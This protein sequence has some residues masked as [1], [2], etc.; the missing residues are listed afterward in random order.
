MLIALAPP[1]APRLHEIR[2]DALVLGFTALITLL[3]VMVSG[4]APAGA[5]ARVHLTASLRDGG[6]EA[7]STGRLRAGLVIAEIAIALVLVVGAALLVQTP[8]LP[9]PSRG[10]NASYRPTD[11]VTVDLLGSLLMTETLPAM[12]ENG[13][14]RPLRRPK[15]LAEHLQVTLGVD[16][17]EQVSPLSDVAGSLSSEDAQDCE[18]SSIV[19]SSASIAVSGDRVAL[20]TSVA[21]DVLANK[22]NDLLSPRVGEHLLPVPVVGELRYGPQ[23]TQGDRESR[24]GGTSR[25]PGHILNV[26]SHMPLGRVWLFLCCMLL[27]AFAAGQDAPDISGP[28]T[29]TAVRLA[30]D[31]RLELDGVL[32]EPVWQRATP[33]GGFLQREPATGA[34]A[35]EP[36]EVRVVYDARRLVL[37]VV[38]H[39]SQPEAILQNEMRRDGSFDADDSFAWVIDSFVDGRTGYFFEINPAGAMGDG[40][41]A[42][43]AGGGGGGGGGGGIN[44]SW[45]GI[46]IARVRRIETGW[47]AEIEIPFRTL[48]FN[49]DLTAW[50]INFRRTVRRKNEESLWTGYALNQGL[51]R[52]INAGRLEGLQGLSQGVG[53]DIKPYVVGHLSSAPAFGRPS[54]TATSA[55]TRSTTS[56]PPC[57]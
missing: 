44:R 2:I 38:L 57:S 11:Q 45:D 47:T 54:G 53:L 56:R 29:F 13:A 24:Q 20:D 16:V 27:P 6:R 33:A 26:T 23:L 34:P 51:T 18:R 55:S 14:F 19:S 39:D 36:T 48:N 17:P 32:D 15:G 42:L 3:T 28:R 30:P 50:G 12:F 25:G 10:A 9:L 4:L 49:P 40:L 7:T 31:E 43:S 52:V 21:I 35:T 41:V 5:A 8:D 22:A 46:W 1:S 37:G